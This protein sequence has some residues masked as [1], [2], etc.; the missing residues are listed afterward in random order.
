MLVNRWYCFLLLLLFFS[1]KEKKQFLLEEMKDTGIDFQNNVFNT[2]ELNI[3]SY[4]NFYNGGGV[5]IG[6]L[7]NDGLSDVFFTANMGANKVYLNKGNWVFEDV[8]V[9]A[10]FR[11]KKKW[12]TGVSMVDVNQD[13]F[14]DIY[15]CYAGNQQGVD[16]ENELWI[17]D[18][19]MHFTEQ[20]K[21]Y[22]LNDAGFTTHA[23]FFDYDIDG[24]LDCYILNNSFI[25]VN[26]LNY[27]NKRELRASE[28]P[29]DEKLKG[30]GDKL[31]RN[32][33]GIFHD[34]SEQA[35]IYGSLIGF[36]LGVTVGDVN[37]DKL[38]DIYVSNDFFERDYLYINKGNGTFSE[39]LTSRIRHVSHSSMG[40]DM[41][42]LNNDGRNDIF[43]T[44]MLPDDE[45]RLKTTIT[46]ESF[47]VFNYKVKS[48]F[49]YQFMQNTLQK[50]NGN[51]LFSEVAQYSGVAA[52]DWSWGALL[53]DVDND[54]LN[55]IYVC[56]GIYRDLTD[57]DFIDFFADRA[58][59]DMVDIREK[60]GVDDI[61]SKMPSHPLR[62][63]FFHN[64][65]NFR[66]TD[67]GNAFG[68]ETASFSNG[69]AY[70]DLDNDGDLDLIVNNLN[71]PAFVY[72]NNSREITKH[73][74]VGVILES[75]A[76][77]RDAIGAHI[78]VYSNGSVQQR[79]VM[80]N[81]GYQSSVDRKVIFGL[82]STP[83]IDSLRIVW[84]NRTY[85]TIHSVSPDTVYRFTPS[86]NDRPLVI[87]PLPKPYLKVA[88]NAFFEPHKEDEFNDFNQERNI[89]RMRSKEGPAVAAADVDADGR[90]DVFIGGAA[91]YPAQLYLQKA[92]GFTRSNQQ[93]FE[94]EKAFEDVAAVFFD[95]DQDGDADLVVGSGGNNSP[96]GSSLMANRLYLNDGKGYF[97]R[98][99]DAFP[100]ATG[101]TNTLIARDLDKDGDLDIF[102]ASSS[103]PGNHAV[104]PS[105]MIYR[106]DG[107]AN[108]KSDPEL[109]SPLGNG[110]IRAAAFADLDNDGSD[111]LIM[112]GE[113][114]GTEIYSFRDGKFQRKETTLAGL[115]GW[116]YSMVIEDLDQDGDP[117]LV[118]GNNGPNFYLHPDPQHPVRMWVNRFDRTDKQQVVI[119]RTV[120]G[121][122]VPVF[123]KK[124][125]IDQM[126]ELKKQNLKHADYAG[127]SIQELFPKEL[128]NSS[129]VYQY[130]YSKSVIFWNEGN[131]RFSREELPMDIQLSAITAILATDVNADGK[132]DLL[133]GSNMHD[134]LPQFSRMDAGYG[135]LLIQGNKKAF[136][137]VELEASGMQ[138]DG[139][140]RKILPLKINGTVHYLYVRNNAAPVLFQSARLAKNPPGND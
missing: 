69:A 140:I 15:V 108:F 33:G 88:E 74:Y 58:V 131:F 24:D 82:G 99:Q 55:D 106:N 119:T 66:F 18:G 8:S 116:W 138:V 135:A 64:K 90:E 4:R 120:D 122:D 30:G 109:A 52:S 9:A 44:E 137:A 49:H 128:I 46:F 21:Q 107:K 63:K 32:D 117:D 34:V 96:A 42:D 111:E 1:C 72:R 73:H 7:N 126:P 38:P 31:M 14:L 26:T 47:D 123:L 37:G 114:M 67:A 51:G 27:S 53:F 40:A 2:S 91:G 125:L 100:P 29:V 54:G 98:K 12:S 105:P 59:Q 121:K 139:Q 130:D 62:N 39:E 113:W 93:L 84:P 95:A 17:N 132:K 43:V 70:G 71:Q 22:G 50:N 3:F 83:K 103:S 85:R 45:K 75:A 112:T 127:R 61:V 5:A 78:E 68:I 10:G 77:N 104:M 136:D 19:K 6:D 56:N 94:A 57:Q 92:K 76:P 97:T 80:P 86:V 129:R 36:G 110:M 13:G 25:P 124:E 35:G 133:F 20:A 41:A 48:G 79:E 23:V 11:D 65:G 102:S 89:L 60:E 28:W 134:W 115:H 87:A 118:L 101:N 16:T 81:R